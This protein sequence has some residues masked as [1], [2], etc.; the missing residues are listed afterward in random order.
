MKHESATLHRLCGVKSWTWLSKPRALFILNP[1]SKPKILSVPSQAPF[2]HIPNM[3]E[4]AKETGSQRKNYSWNMLLTTQH[5][6]HFLGALGFPTKR[7]DYS[8]TRAALPLPNICIRWQNVDTHNLLTSF[9]KLNN[10]FTFLKILVSSLSLGLPNQKNYLFS[11]SH[12]FFL[13]IVWI[14]RKEEDKKHLANFWLS[15]SFT[16]S[17]TLSLSSVHLTNLFVCIHYHSWLM[18][19]WS[20]WTWFWD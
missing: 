19:F 2:P 13:D 7:I 11:H 20:G 17:T 3:Y 18:W 8:S 14:G 4:E 1:R 6:F 12:P 16:P 5:S 9:W 10:T 15:L